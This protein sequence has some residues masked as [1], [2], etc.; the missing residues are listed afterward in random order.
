MS[1]EANDVEVTTKKKT[2]LGPWI[3]AITIALLSNIGWAVVFL[4][5]PSQASAEATAVAPEAAEVATGSAREPGP[6]MDLNHFVV[7]L[8]D[9]GT[10]RYLR[11]GI[12][13]ELNAEDD[14]TTVQKYLVPLRDQYI[15]H[16]SSLE[17][18][19][20]LSAQDKDDLKA[21]LME[22]TES[23]L[24]QRAVREIYF[25]EFMMQ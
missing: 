16:L 11:I 17:P 15:R 19:Q 18:S 23:V 14:R 21:V 6:L 13:L 2:G 24:P 20:L 4:H 9:T 10:T 5:S 3:A 1:N 25:T 12:S 7:N 22:R 8:N